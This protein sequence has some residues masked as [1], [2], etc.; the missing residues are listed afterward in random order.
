MG[1]F[2]LA[3]CLRAYYTN[4]V[5]QITTLYMFDEITILEAIANDDYR[6]LE[7]IASDCYDEDDAIM[8]RAY[9][10]TAYHN[11][12]GYDQSINN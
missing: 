1:I 6:M 4:D 8:Y 10:N 12:W 5:T 11:C 2:T 9:A 3:M 7:A